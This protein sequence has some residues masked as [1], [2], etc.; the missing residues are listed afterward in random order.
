M[1]GIFAY[2]GSGPRGLLTHGHEVEPNFRMLHIIFV[3]W[4][5]AGPAAKIAKCKTVVVN[6]PHS[7]MKEPA[8]PPRS[9]LYATVIICARPFVDIRDK[10]N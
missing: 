10:A 1:E 9:R 8:L 7:K 2:H 3:N 4:A 6:H 5:I